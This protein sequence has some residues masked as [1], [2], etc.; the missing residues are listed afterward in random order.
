MISTFSVWDAFETFQF[1]LEKKDKVERFTLEDFA[2]SV[3]NHD[4][5]SWPLW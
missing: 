3:V 2:K 5:V 4:Q 1:Y